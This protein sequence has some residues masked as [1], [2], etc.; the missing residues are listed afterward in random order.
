MGFINTPNIDTLLNSK[1][2]DS[3]TR[4]I[5]ILPSNIPSILVRHFMFQNLYQTATLSIFPTHFQHG[6]HFFQ[7][8]SAPFYL[9]FGVTVGV[10]NSVPHPSGQSPPQGNAVVTVAAVAGHP[11]TEL[12]VDTLR[13]IGLMQ[14]E[15]I[16]FVLVTVG[17]AGVMVEVGP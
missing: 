16:V 8:H 1:T 15:Q 13:H 9:Q 6:L 12:T 4:I 10:T 3:A 17:Q 14:S 11:Q 5:H 2:T 7:P